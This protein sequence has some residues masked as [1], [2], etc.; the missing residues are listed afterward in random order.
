MYQMPKG[1]DSIVLY[2]SAWQ[3]EWHR[4]A[5]ARGLAVQNEFFDAASAQRQQ[6]PPRLLALASAEDQ[7]HRRELRKNAQFPSPMTSVRCQ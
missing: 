2:G 3:H 5:S 1:M 6:L 4:F 7:I